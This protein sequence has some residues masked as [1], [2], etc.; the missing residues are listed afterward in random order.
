[1]TVPAPIIAAA[2]GIVAGLAAS[3]VMN[4]YQ[5]RTA[6]LFGLGD[7]DEDPATVR[8]A[9]TVSEATVGAPIPRHRRDAAGDIV[10]YATGAGLGLVYAPLVW[11][12]PGAATGFGTLF[13]VTVA[14][15]L[16]DLIVPEFG[17]GE[18]PWRTP[19]STHLYGISS[20]IVFG[21]VLEGGRRALVALPG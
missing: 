8:V 18:W 14:L 11:A 5:A 9:D 17:L 16:D 21:A 13:G 4:A 12:W 6:S 20:H 15:V 2:A 10:H 1:M 19:A 7:S 3:W